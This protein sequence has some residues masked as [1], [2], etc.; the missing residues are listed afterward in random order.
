VVVVVVVVVGGGGPGLR[1]SPG[2]QEEKRAFLGFQEAKIP[3]SAARLKARRHEKGKKTEPL[4][5][6]RFSGDTISAIR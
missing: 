3:P 1:G 6:R 2:S 5:E 4:G